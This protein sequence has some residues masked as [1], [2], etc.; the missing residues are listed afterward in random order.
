MKSLDAL[1]LKGE[2]GHILPYLGYAD[3]DI[4]IDGNTYFV[5]VLIIQI[6]FSDEIPLIIGTN[7]LC[8]T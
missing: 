6:N 3:M 4:L 5:P 2:D 1:L 7:H 8:K